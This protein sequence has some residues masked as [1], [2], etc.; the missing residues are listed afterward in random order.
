MRKRD[1]STLGS[2]KVEVQKKERSKKAQVTKENKENIMFLSKC[3]VCNDQK[4]KID[5][6]QEAGRLLSSLGLKAPFSSIP[7][8]CNILYK[9][10]STR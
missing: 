6:K 8:V 10:V 2:P 3:E 1:N 4:I 5:Q 9:E 7:L